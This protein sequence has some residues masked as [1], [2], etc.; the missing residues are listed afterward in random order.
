MIITKTP[1]RLSFF[2]GGTDYNSWF[3]R[4]GGLVIGCTMARYCYISLRTLPPFF[5]HKTQVV[6]SKLETVQDNSQIKHPSVNACLKYLNVKDG[7]EIHHD[8]DL[9]ARSGIGSSSSFTSGMLLALHAYKNEMITKEQLAA[10]T[11]E[12]EQNVIGESVG[13][14]DQ[15]LASYGGLN[16]I[17]MGPGA[18]Y[19]VSPLIL[20]PD[21]LENLE[22][23]ILLGFTGITRTASEHAKAQIAQIERGKSDSQLKDIHAIAKEGLGLLS[24]KQELSKV[25]RL[26]DTTWKI[27]RSMSNPK[28]TSF[29]DLIYE[30]ALQ[31]GAIGG[32]LMGAGGGGFMVFIAPPE[33]HNRIKENLK[34]AI[35]VWV[36]F[37]FDHEGSQILFFSR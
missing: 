3:E 16:I 15:I 37:K 17:E 19:Q 18:R 4:N 32:R 30:K 31:A 33:T 2:G 24:T 21:Y 10:E 22:S 27:K 23:H 35:K 14:Q 26:F 36:P 8:G 1:Y 7:L 6:Y 28:D 34:D 5:D 13:V 25:G 29:A 11:I 9:P 20:P 12:V